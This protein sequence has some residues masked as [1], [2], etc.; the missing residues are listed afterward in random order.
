M[1]NQ[2]P[3]ILLAMPR[4]S[5]IHE[6]I[7]E[8]LQYCG[9]EVIEILPPNQGFR[10][11]NLRSRIKVKFQQIVLHQKNAKQKLKD[12][13]M[14]EMYLQRLQSHQVIDYALFIRPDVFGVQTV[15]AL[16]HHVRPDGFVAY[17]WDGMGRFPFVWDFV[18]LFDR[19]FVF[20]K[21][22]CYKNAQLLHTTN[23][24]FDHDLTC[25]QPEIHDFYYLGSHY[26][27][28]MPLINRFLAFAVAQGWQSN[29]T[30]YSDKENVPKHYPIGNV[31]WIQKPLS[32]KENL[33]MTKQS[34]ILVD[35]VIGAHKGLSL[36]VF[37]ALGFRKKL[38][39]T[40]AE[41]VQYDFYHPDNI[42]VLTENNLDGLPEFLA[43]P[44]HEIDPNIRE[45]Y[46]FSNWIRHIL[47]IQP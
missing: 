17:Q 46:S 10:Y 21:Q 7:K 45:K 36:R 30:I 24:Y 38:I 31:K 40:N 25:R 12:Q 27:D 35:F 11:P 34:R 29:F 3:T 32:F 18:A 13:I 42:Y 44:H 6:C 43:Q 4:D 16:R 1:T 39:T 5:Q 20:D 9:F 33:E 23:F 28:R 15:K 14:C 37:E 19:F 26:K 2:K 47:N 8:N 22:D 41:I